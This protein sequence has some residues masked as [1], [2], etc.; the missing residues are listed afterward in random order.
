MCPG[1]QGGSDSMCVLGVEGSEKKC[2]PP[3]DNFWNS[4]KTGTQAFDKSIV[5]LSICSTLHDKVP[6]GIHLTL[7]PILFLWSENLEAAY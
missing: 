4:P 1:G 6:S 5:V 3:Q 2:A 7:V